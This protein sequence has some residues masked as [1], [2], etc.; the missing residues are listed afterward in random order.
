ML[1][2]SFLVPDAELTC[3]PNYI[4]RA[5]VEPALVALAT[6]LGFQCQCADDC[7]VL[8]VNTSVFTRPDGLQVNITRGDGYLL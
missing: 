3:P 5:Y 2:C 1:H 7:P 8:L 4:D 6:E